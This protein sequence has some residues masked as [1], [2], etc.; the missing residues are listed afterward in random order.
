MSK[1]KAAKTIPENILNVTVKDHIYFDQY[2][3]GLNRRVQKILLDTQ[4]EI[5]ASIARID[6]TEPQSS[7]WK[8]ARLEKLNQDI[9]NILDMGFNEIQQDVQTGLNGAGALKAEQV[10]KSLNK[11]VGADIFNITLT[12]ANVKAIIE[13]TLIDG[14][15][16]SDWWDAQKSAATE[17]TI[18][19][20][21]EGTQALQI[22]MMQG[23]SISELVGRI[24]GSKT[25]VGVMNLTK[26]EAATLVRT[27]V[28][29]VANNVRTE[30][31]KANADVIQAIQWVSVLDGRTTPLCRAADGKQWTMDLQPIGHDMPYPGGPP[32]T[33]NC[34]STI[35][36]ITKSWS[37]LSGANSPLTKEQ[38]AS[39]DNIPQGQRASMD[40]PVPVM[41]YDEWLSGQSEA[42]QQDILGPAR[43]ELWKIKKL[44][45]ADMIDNSGHPLTLQE[46]YKKYG[47]T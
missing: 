25:R 22:G 3:A 8:Q 28:M 5:A 16:I 45:M 1:E 17:K 30:I 18:A 24:K 47:E 10:V 41:N 46:L 42:T 31:Y 35:V 13:S 14:R 29:Q 4:N 37:E 38:I 12:P 20:M 43:F 32:A 6:P 11:A 33:W 15:L 26:R 23:E 19:Q 7:K 34:R 39:L 44:D 27:S 40:G 36:P 9:T 21:K 2:S